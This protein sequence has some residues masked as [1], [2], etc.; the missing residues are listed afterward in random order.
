MKKIVSMLLVVAI[1][2]VFM[3]PSMA[4]GNSTPD[5]GLENAIKYAKS[6]ID[7]PKELTKF[8]YNIY[9]R[10]DQMVWSLQWSDQDGQKYVSVQIDEDNF[11]SSYN[12]SDYMV[13][14]TKK[15]PKYSKEQGRKT[16]EGFVNNL[17]PKL[18]DQFKFND[19]DAYG[20]NGEY[21]FNYVRQLN[22]IEYNRDY[23]N[24]SVDSITGKVIS[25]S[26]NYSKNTKFED[27]SKIISL[28]EAE[29]AF[30]QKLGLKLV[31]NVKTEDGKPVT[32]LAYVPKSTN[33][34]IDAVT[35]DVETLINF[36]KLYDSE[37]G[38]MAKSD[39]MAAS[40]TVS[41]VALTPD[42]LDAVNDISNLLTKEGA[43]QKLRSTSFFN[44]DSS[45]KLTDAYL[46]KDWRNSNSL[47]WTLTYSK[48][49]DESKK[50]TRD[51]QV[52]IDAKT[53]ALIEFWTNYISPEGTTPKKTADEARAICENSLKTLIPDTYAKV[54]FDD[55]YM[56]YGSKPENDYT[57]RYVRMENGLECPN[58]YISVSYDNLSGNIT[59][60][61]TY[62]T[63]ELK[64]ADSK[65]VISIQEANKVLYNKIGFGVQYLPDNS[66]EVETDLAISK[67]VVTADKAVLGYL[68]DTTKPCVISAVDGKLLDNNG[69]IYKDNKIADYTDINGTKAEDKVRILTQLD[70]RYTEDEL[71]PGD[72]L[73]QK[74]YFI[75]LCKLNDLYYFDQSMDDA[76]LVD[77]MYNQ[78]ISMGIITKAEKSPLSVLT[79]EE[80]AKYFIKFM[81][82]SQVAEIKGIY[83]SNFKDANKIN[84]ELLGYVCLA[85]GL[86]VMNGSNGN[87][88]PKTKMTRLDGLLTI[89]NYLST[90]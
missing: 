42:E 88:M 39:I 1:L 80:A 40:G 68:P 35:G 62:W 17:N 47:A 20:Y 59:G 53:G 38:Q 84:P 56:S 10:N 14:N 11:I 46:G 41:N 31:Y 75:V 2:A 50:L 33:K 48:V 16:A 37:S 44:L 82:L 63:K 8:S 32:Y 72:A 3:I 86:K 60:F 66:E 61:Y 67:G 78:L 22:G 57:F 52:T 28:N 24:I 64:F 29:N 36:Y 70:I 54:K 69:N 27:A 79:R 65:N 74:D 81:R 90:K 15:I 6:K 18:L 49:L 58:D 55:S 5:K 77:N 26:C 89:Y 34:Y 87:F 73:L 30:A 12:A 25:Y 51:I 21:N 13:N 83:K 19:S 7:I 43:D 71:K 4:A 76:K 23:I 85:S 9:N 45:F